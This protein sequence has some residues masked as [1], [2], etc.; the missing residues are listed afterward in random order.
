MLV[1]FAIAINVFSSIVYKNDPNVIPMSSARTNNLFEKTGVSRQTLP[2]V[3]SDPPAFQASKSR[4]P[5]RS[6]NYFQPSSTRMSM[7]NQII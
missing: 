6:C 7:V 1:Q 4:S 3:E 5:D 2:E